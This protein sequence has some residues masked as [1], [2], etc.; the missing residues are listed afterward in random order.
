MLAQGLAI[1]VAIGSTFLFLTA[2]IFPKLHRQD[3]FF[4]SAVG[5]FYALILWV[6]AG[7]MAGAVLLGQLASV[8]LLGWFAWE[9]LRLRQA[10]I[11]PTKIPNLDQVSL[12]GYVKEQLNRS[13]APP[14][15]KQPVAADPRSEVTPE[16]A[17]QT[18]D[19][20]EVTETEA[21]PES[22]AIIEPVQPETEEEVTTPEVTAES[23]V[24]VAEATDAETEPEEA[25]EAISGE[26]ESEVIATPETTEAEPETAEL[27]AEQTESEPEV[28]ADKID[29]KGFSFG[30]LFGRKEKTTEEAVNP[31]NL[32]DIFE[33]DGEEESSTNS[34][35]ESA[36]VTTD[37][38]ETVSIDEIEVSLDVID[39]ASTE[40][41]DVETEK[42]AD[43]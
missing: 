33:G 40:D 19:D 37:E 25:S 32:D 21:S 5:L 23:D 24:A 3:D 43:K 27:E 31:Q 18:A 34:D 2:F 41:S 9:T 15:A 4:W 16:E 17:T 39:E 26:P 7:Q 1:A 35:A 12:V 14:K 20:P 11:D 36:S 10:I 38:L 29:K 8:I 13:P 42:E 30:R 28:P 6:C 22:E